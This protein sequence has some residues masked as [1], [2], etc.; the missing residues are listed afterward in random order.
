MPV[1][2]NSTTSLSDWLTYLESIHPTTIDMGLDRMR[3]VANLLSLDFSNGKVITVAGTNGKGTTCRF[4]EQALLSQGKR[5]GVYSSPHLVDYRERVRVGGDMLPQQDYVDALNA[6]ENARGDIS[7]TYFEFGTLAALVMF[8]QRQLDFVILEVGLGGRLDATNIVDTDLAVVTSI[9]VDHQ[10]WLGDTRELIAIEKAGI[11]RRDVPVIMGDLD[12]PE[13]LAQCVDAT[14]SLA[15]WVNRDFSFSADVGAWDWQGFGRTFASLSETKIP[16]QNVST[17]LA[18]LC[19]LDLLP[20]TDEL[21]HLINSTSMPGRMQVLKSEPTV[22]LDVAHNPQATASLSAWLSKYDGT[23]MHFVVGM[24]AD[25]A[26]TD[27]LSALTRKPGMW[28]VASTAGPRGLSCDKLA[29][30][31]PTE[32]VE[33]THNNVTEAYKCAISN[34]QPEDVIVVFGSFLTVADVLAYESSVDAQ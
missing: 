11:M 23:K 2:P 22:V 4:I 34:A 32:L 29:E 7:L 26:I 28:Y 21:Q 10:D 30:C 13:T 24:L 8:A 14:G 17:A 16:R 19:V 33:S 6:V 18:A 27:T 25:K 3:A 15:Y 20:K 5:V 1:S 9:G 12:P 31:L